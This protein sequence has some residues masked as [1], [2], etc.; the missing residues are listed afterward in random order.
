MCLFL[1][2]TQTNMSKI[3]VGNGGGRGVAATAIT[4]AL[5]LMAS[6]AILTT[7]EASKAS[8]SDNNSK[9]CNPLRFRGAVESGYPTYAGKTVTIETSQNEYS[10]KLDYLLVEDYFGDVYYKN[11]KANDPRGPVLL[12][13]GKTITI[14]FRTVESVNPGDNLVTL[15]DHNVSDCQILLDRAGHVPDEDKMVLKIT[16]IEQS[17]DNPSIAK[18]TV[19]VP[20]ASEVG[21]HF[22]KLG[23]Q[24]PFYPELDEYY[25]ISHRVQVS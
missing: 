21:K 20:D 8:K 19:Q 5:I 16:S 1:L 22:T 7:T 6:P 18:V 10:V 3:I 2:R 17:D 12:P 23:V 11:L 15:Y 9:D 13:A 24:F 14:T 4:V 25:I